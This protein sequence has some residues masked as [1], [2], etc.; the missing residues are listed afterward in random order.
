MKVENMCSFF[1]KYIE[2]DGKFGI[3]LNEL[4]NAITN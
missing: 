2:I 1:I 3:I 4:Q